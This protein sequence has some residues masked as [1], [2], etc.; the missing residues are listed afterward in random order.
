MIMIRLFY[1]TVMI[2]SREMC[3]AQIAIPNILHYTNGSKYESNLQTVFKNLVEHTSQTGFNTSVYGQSPDRISGLLQCRGDTTVAQCYNCAQLATTTVKQQCGNAIGCNIWYDFCFLRFENSTFIGQIN[4]NMLY[5]VEEGRAYNDIVA[6]V[7]NPDVFIAAL[8]KLLSKL[9]AEAPYLKERSA[10][11]MTV[12]S[13]L[14]KIYGQVE[15]TR[16]ISSANCTTCLSTAINYILAIY[17]GN[18]GVE[19]FMQNCIVRYGINSFFNL[20]AL[21]PSPAE[22]P[23]K[24]I[25]Q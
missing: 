11:D 17:P 12:D 7:T 22:A 3:N 6:N 21:P 9:S 1:I 15:C 13:L 8:D 24:Q 5:T 25:T 14:R 10:F 23:P 4:T 18:R 16:D 2:L 19:S 20:T